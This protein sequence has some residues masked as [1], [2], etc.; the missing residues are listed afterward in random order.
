[1][2]RVEYLGDYHPLI[3]SLTAETAATPP[4]ASE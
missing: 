4:P 2:Y 3:T 1:M